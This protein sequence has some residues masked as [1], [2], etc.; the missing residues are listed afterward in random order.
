[1]NSK[2]SIKLETGNR[3]RSK[4]G[5]IS[6]IPSLSLILKNWIDNAIENFYNKNLTVL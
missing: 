3:N 2:F 4:L 5:I 1:L 6:K